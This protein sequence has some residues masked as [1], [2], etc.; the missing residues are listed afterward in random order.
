MFIINCIFIIHCIFIINCIFITHC[1]FIINCIFITHCIYKYKIIKLRRTC[2]HNPWIA[3]TKYGSMDCTNPYFAL[4][5]YIGE[6]F[7]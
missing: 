3:R 6:F 4:N 7:C 2:T 1:I 5:I